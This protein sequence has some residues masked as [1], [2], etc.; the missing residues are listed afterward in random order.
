MK[1]TSNFNALTHNYAKLPD[2]KFELC[3]VIALLVLF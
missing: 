2:I 3:L 1:L